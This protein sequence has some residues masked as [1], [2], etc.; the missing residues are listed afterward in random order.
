MLSFSASSGEFCWHSYW[1]DESRAQSLPSN[2]RNISIT[3]KA[4]A[5]GRS[6]MD[7]RQT[8]LYLVTEGSP[9]TLPESGP[10]MGGHGAASEW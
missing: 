8:F 3:L 4:P 9:V 7:G 2:C 6:L 1:Q 10:C 5:F